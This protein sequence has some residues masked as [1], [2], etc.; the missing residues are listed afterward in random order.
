MVQY[1]DQDPNFQLLESSV[2]RNLW[3]NEKNLTSDQIFDKQKNI[4]DELTFNMYYDLQQ[5]YLSKVCSYL[6]N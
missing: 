3:G 1:G 6:L 2:V 4:S 5:H